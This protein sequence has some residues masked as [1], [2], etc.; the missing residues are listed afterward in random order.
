MALFDNYNDPIPHYL[1]L[2]WNTYKNAKPFLLILR[3]SKI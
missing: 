2:G 1:Y 3:D